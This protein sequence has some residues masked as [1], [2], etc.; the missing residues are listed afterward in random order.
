MNFQMFTANFNGSLATYLNLL[1][2]F[3]LLTFETFIQRIFNFSPSIIDHW[4][5]FHEERG[6]LNVES[7][8]ESSYIFTGRGRG[9][10]LNTVQCCVNSTCNRK[11][12]FPENEVLTFHNINI[13]SSIIYISQDILLL[14][15]CFKHLHFPSLDM[16]W[17]LYLILT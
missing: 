10:G 12:W 15:L 2:Q 3:Q 16:N 17:N 4:N 13:N 9:L 14:G 8:A 5:Q 6:V 11:L 7:W 1:A